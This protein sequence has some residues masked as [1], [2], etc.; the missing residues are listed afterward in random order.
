MQK[1]QRSSTAWLA[2][3]ALAVALLALGS[4][5]R[6]PAGTGALPP[7]ALAPTDRQRM[8]ARQVGSILEEA[9]FRRAAIDD[10]LS[11]EVFDKYLDFM[12]G[13]RSYFL[14]SDIAEFEALRL[15][16]DDMIRSGD[17]DPAY[18]IFARFQQRNRERI[19]FA[20]SQL[21]NTEPDWTARRVVR[22]RPQESRPWPTSTAE[23]DEM[24]RKRV[25]NDALSLLLAGKEWKDAADVL[26]QALRAGA[27][28][29]RPDQPGRRVREPDELVRAHVFDPHSSYFSPRSSEEYRIQMSLNYEGIGASLQLID[30]YVTVM[31]VIEGGPP[32]RPA[33]SASTTASPRWARART[34]R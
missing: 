24:W 32:P 26:Q 18:G 21:D 17:I 6:A 13:Q 34:A 4:S 15:R 33:R 5:S 12:D 8:I 31:N 19:R 22:V 25:K 16:F 11:S 1:A 27:E 9:H 30:D 28:A 20:L 7:G 29:R 2:A 10:R 23:L 14:A 3:S